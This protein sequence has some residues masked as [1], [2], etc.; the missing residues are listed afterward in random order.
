MTDADPAMKIDDAE[1]GPALAPFLLLL[2][3]DIKG[4]AEALRPLSERLIARI[5]LLT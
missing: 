5:N 1:T 3:L 2:A 4:R